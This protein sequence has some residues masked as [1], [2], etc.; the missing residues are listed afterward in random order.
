MSAI[1]PAVFAEVVEA[2]RMVRDADEDC[3][4]DGLPT[5]PPMARAKIDH[6]L[7]AAG[8]TDLRGEVRTTSPSRDIEALRRVIE[9]AYGLLW[10]ISAAPG[11]RH[12]EARKLLL[13]ATDRAGQGRGI[14]WAVENFG[15]P[16]SPPMGD[17]R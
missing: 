8:V 14:A 10:M 9:C 12:H 7:V 17:G 3:R 13:A 4:A 5:M 15:P 16:S 11:S 1:D 6:A 2:L